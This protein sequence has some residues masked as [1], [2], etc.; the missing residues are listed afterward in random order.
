MPY[1]ETSYALAQSVGDRKTMSY[2]VR[3][4]GFT[5]KEAGRFDRA[6]AQLTESVSL[7]REIG[8][9]PGV[10]AGLVALGYL[11]AETG[12]REAAIGYLDEARTTAEQCGAKGVLGW[13]E[14]ARSQ[15][16]TECRRSAAPRRHVCSLDHQPRS[17]RVCVGGA[18]SWSRATTTRVRN[19]RLRRGLQRS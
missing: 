8:F 18:P 10:A 15:I 19:A 11:S 14:R 3:H 4:L 16:S 1:F 12:D 17:A 7:R 9:L 2:S 6:R 5:E 13:D